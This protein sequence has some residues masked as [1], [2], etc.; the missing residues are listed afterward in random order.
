MLTNNVVKLGVITHFKWRIAIRST[1]SGWR[2][3]KKKYWPMLKLSAFYLKMALT[4]ICMGGSTAMRFRQVWRG[5]EW[6]MLRETTLTPDVSINVFNKTAQAHFSPACRRLIIIRNEGATSCGCNDRLYHPINATLHHTYVRFTGK[7]WSWS[8]H[9]S[10]HW[11]W[12]GICGLS[13]ARLL[14]TPDAYPDGTDGHA[15]ASVRGGWVIGVTLLVG[16]ALGFRD[17]CFPG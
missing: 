1:I 12:N 8:Q 13:K 7:D 4:L 9:V 14:E 15:K 6:E 2:N 3:R 16:A 17:L 11:E 10:T 5:Q